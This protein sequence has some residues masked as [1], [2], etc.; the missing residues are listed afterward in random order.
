MFLI[1][2]GF[3]DKCSRVGGR[4]VGRIAPQELESVRCQLSWCTR[5]CAYSTVLPPSDRSIFQP[6]PLSTFWAVIESQQPTETNNI[7]WRDTPYQ[8]SGM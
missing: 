2:T 4:L 7:V 1:A 5:E 3:S 6:S 8:C